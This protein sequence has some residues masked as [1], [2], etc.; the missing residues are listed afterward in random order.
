MRITYSPL[1]HTLV[2]KNITRT[3]LRKGIELNNVTY[4]RLNKG[5]HISLDNIAKICEFLDCKIE[6]VIKVDK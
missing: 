3:E 6:D 1:W 2:D 4:A 5:E